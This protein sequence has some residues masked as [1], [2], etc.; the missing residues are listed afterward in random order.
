VD[1][2]LLRRQPRYLGQKISIGPVASSPATPPAHLA[3]ART[4]LTR[5]LVAAAIERSHVHVRYVAD[6]ARI[7][8]PGG[9]VPSDTGTCTDE[10]IRIYRPVGIDL[11]KEVHEDM[12]EHFDQY[13]KQKRWRLGHPD[14]NIDHRR[15]PNLI[16]FFRS[17]GENLATTTDAREYLPGDIVA[18]NLGFGSTHIGMVVDQR[19]WLS[20]RYIILHNR[21]GAE[22]RRRALRLE[23][24]RTLPVLRAKSLTKRVA[25]LF[26]LVFL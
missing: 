8:Y 11:Q 20:N 14:T 16:T 18:W 24:H 23:D 15:A 1:V 19:G 4:A 17:R 21:G 10:I 7:P 12:L 13:P 3:A 26:S 6:Y 25:A 5:Q 22:N 2:F 9:D